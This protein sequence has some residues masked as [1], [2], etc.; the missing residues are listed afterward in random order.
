MKAFKKRGA[1]THFQ[2][3]SEISKQNPNLK[4]KDLAETLGIT[5][6][7]V[8]ENIK[9]LIEEGYITSK[10][11]R[12]PYKITQKGIDKVKKDAIVLR[13]Y[14]DSVLE[15]MNHFKTV[16]PAIANEKLKEGEKVGLYMDGGV[17]YASKQPASATGTVLK[18][19]EKGTDVALGG[20]TGL[21][22]MEVGEAI[23]VTLPNIKNGGSDAADLDLIMNIYEKGT[24]HGGKIDKIAIVGTVSRSITNQLNLPVD[25]EFA[26]AAGTANACRKGLNVLVLS[27]GDMTKAFIRELEE[28]KIKYNIIDGIK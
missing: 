15:T 4:Q 3:L 8:S 27:V 18:D 2:I 9:T 1:L 21:I 28:E 16:W 24:Q 25:I 6:Q 12:S 22:D 5:I 14:T 26:A 7:A 19:A 20:L 11:G 13:K 10:D 17:L 23:I